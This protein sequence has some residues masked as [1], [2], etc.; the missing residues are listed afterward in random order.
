MYDLIII[1]AGPAGLTAAIYAGRSRFKTLVLEK[2][3]VG[4]QVALT[5]TIENF[6]GFPGGINSCEL[7]E[8][9]KKQAEEFGAEIKLGEVLEINIKDKIKFIKTHEQTYETKTLILATGAQPKNLNIPGE[10][11]FANKGVSYC[12]TC[13][14]PFFKNKEIVVVGGGD[15]ALEEALYLTRFA[16]KVNILHRRDK[17]R[18]AKILEEH[19]G[20]NSKIQ[21]VLESI[22]L[23]ILGE[24]SVTGIKIKNV[25]TNT[26]SILSC[27]GIFIFV[28]LKPN[29][30]FLK[31]ITKLDEEGYILTNENL[32]VSE[33]GIF[34]CGDCR[35]KQF[36]QIVT[37]C[38]EGAAAAHS[39]SKYLEGE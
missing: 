18:A 6:P 30:S 28:G 20:E 10:K 29:T 39:V 15:T 16:K 32:A 9:F 17:L 35:K 31:D 5:E 3:G 19:A 2:V 11:E 36:R 25:K 38:G 27:Q 37:A 12:G 23:E 24:N 4:G 14:G 13:D 22:P 34:A 1:G 7:I 26:E 33:N 21:F 8:K